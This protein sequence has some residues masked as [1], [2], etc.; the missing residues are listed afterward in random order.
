MLKPSPEHVFL[1][2]AGGARGYL[3]RLACKR[4]L[5]Q[6]I[7][8]SQST[9]D[10][11]GPGVE[12]IEGDAGAIPLPDKSVDRI[13]CHHS[14]DH[15]QGTSD[16]TFIKEVQRL[17]T[18]GGRCC[19]VPLFI[20]DRYSEITDKLSLKFKFDPRSLRVI[21]P[22]ASLPGGKPSGHY[23]RTYDGRAF[24]QRI[25]QH[26]DTSRFRVAV[27]SM[28]IDGQMVPDM[29]LACHRAVTGL[30]FPYR[31]LVIERHAE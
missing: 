18:M 20:V 1:D 23:A 4:R 21:D 19:I 28:T 27:L 16:S 13:S 15:F 2:A 29:S 30:N 31:V 8:I 7:R 22:T 6:D 17:L 3:A 25:L 12:Y 10:Q 5:L 26:I 14:F 9:R 24:Q 11:L